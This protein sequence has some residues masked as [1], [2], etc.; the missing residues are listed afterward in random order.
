MFWVEWAMD[1]QLHQY[2]SAIFGVA[3]NLLVDDEMRPGYLV[4]HVVG[5]NEQHC[6][7]R[8]RHTCDRNLHLQQVGC[9][10]MDKTE[11]IEPHR[12]RCV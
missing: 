2:C 7:E 10:K 9:R 11:H 1:S 8:F 12:F 4:A 5:W 6:Q 3:N